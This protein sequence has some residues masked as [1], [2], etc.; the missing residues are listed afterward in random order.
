MPDFIAEI[1]RKVFLYG[2]G[3]ATFFIFITGITALR[4]G[5]I[6]LAIFDLTAAILLI[7]FLWLSYKKPASSLPIYASLVV[8]GLLFI[9][10]FTTKTYGDMGFIWGV[11]IPMTTPLILGWK[12]GILVSAIFFGICTSISL[13]H[14]IWFPLPGIPEAINL[15]RVAIIYLIS[16][17]ISSFH[18]LLIE[19]FYAKN[20]QTEQA[21]KQ[22][23]ERLDTVL[24]NT[25]AIIYSFQLD[26]QAPVFTYINE[27]IRT[28]LGY[29]PAIFLA[30]PNHWYE[31]LHPKDKESYKSLLLSSADSANPHNRHRSSEFRFI[32]CHGNYRWF[33]IKHQPITHHQKKEIIGAGIDIT[34]QKRTEKKLI[35]TTR[36]AEA[37]NREKSRFLAR[38]SH[39]IRTPMNSIFGMSEL[40]KET[41]L[42]DEQKHYV[43]IFQSST[44]TLLTLINDILDLSKIEAGKLTLINS[45]FDPEKLFTELTD[46]FCP[47]AIEQGL[48]LNLYIDPR[49][50]DELY[51]DCDR[52][53]QVLINLME[54]AVKF[55]E[56]GEIKVELHLLDKT[57]QNT[58]LLFS[59]EDTGPGIPQEKQKTIFDSFTQVDESP[60][61]TH[62]GSGLGLSICKQ[63]IKKM[64]G[65]ISVNSKPGK[66]SKFQFQ[67][68]LAYRNRPD[69]S[70][71]LNPNN[72]TGAILLFS[73]NKTYLKVIRRYLESTALDL[74]TCCKVEELDD[75]LE[76]LEEFDLV[77]F[78]ICSISEKISQAI[79][80]VA[81]LHRQKINIF[82]PFHL[83]AKN[84]KKIADMQV[85]DHCQR[86]LTQN[87]LLEV[88]PKKLTKPTKNSLDISKK[89]AP[90][91]RLAGKL[92]IIDDNANNRLVA[93]GYLRDQELQIE[94]AENGAEGLKL[95]QKNHYDLVLMDLEM[96]VLDGYRATNQFRS[97]EQEHRGH[98]LPIIALT[99]HAMDDAQSMALKKGCD[100]Y[101]S[102]PF[103]K[104]QLIQLLEQYL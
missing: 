34:E 85:A 20:Q 59:V 39:E 41:I 93:K 91:A 68:S 43:E 32:D 17:G 36:K 26:E 46:F 70:P 77:I 58:T 15:T 95:M 98:R 69:D 73:K 5:D 12:Q 2:L 14:Y 55:T 40:L 63:L 86:P 92:L 33:K 81:E 49:R 61:R 7:I 44:E 100:D 90:S 10:L 96:P 57:D 16:L 6:Q 65:T 4:L 82:M 75:Y 9:Y 37:A 78:S 99:A 87:Q 42:T 27:N 71:D 74:T 18:S 29:S 25:P 22:S 1:R 50:P 97:W 67:L 24:A 56:T 53:R 11:L 13:I 104:A 3:L 54:N 19:N 30:N 47:R 35:K 94:E 80:K 101:L 28:V 8:V 60:A 88:L 31:L 45:Y 102:K 83:I 89:N 38:I 21:L 48:K 51:G 62:Q 23:K 76:N 66:G 64:G 52:L 84:R 72:L 103:K 79:S